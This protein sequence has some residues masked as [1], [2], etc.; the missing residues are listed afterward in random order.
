LIKT[1]ESEILQTYKV[2][3][4]I[5]ELNKYLVMGLCEFALVRVKFRGS[6]GRKIRFEVCGGFFS[7]MMDYD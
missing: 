6:G 2:Y 3:K 4:P 5:G 1:E 7:E